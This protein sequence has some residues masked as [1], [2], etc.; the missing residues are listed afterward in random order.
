MKGQALQNNKAVTTPMLKEY[1]KKYENGLPFNNHHRCNIRL[2]KDKLKYR[3][4]DRYPAYCLAGQKTG[5]DANTITSTG[6][7]PN[8]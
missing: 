5:A 7:R 4:S 3:L 1:L 8:F 2:K 6:T